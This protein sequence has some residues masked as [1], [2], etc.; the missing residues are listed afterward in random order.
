MSIYELS[1]AHERL[2]QLGAL[3]KKDGEFWILP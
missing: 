2:E 3:P 1:L